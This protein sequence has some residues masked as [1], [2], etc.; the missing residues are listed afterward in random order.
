MA[1]CGWRETGRW[2]KKKSASLRA[3]EEERERGSE[4]EG[5][6]RWGGAGGKKE[7]QGFG[8]DV[9]VS[10]RHPSHSPFL[11]VRSRAESPPAS[12][13]V[14][15]RSKTTPYNGVPAIQATFSSLLCFSSRVLPHIDY[16][17]TTYPSFRLA[18]P[19]PSS[20]VSLPLFRSDRRRRGG[21]RPLIYTCT[22]D[23]NIN[24]NDGRDE[25]IRTPRYLWRLSRLPS[26]FSS[27]ICGRINP[28]PL[29][30]IFWRWIFVV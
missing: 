19:P 17:I 23:H 6:G 30:T 29:R 24:F 7:K 21:T 8:I 2:N 14:P 13:G 20:A 15:P 9:I 27:H 4:R 18:H 16:N 1:P 5:H 3:W 28:L 26:A 25:N 12:H 10:V 22:S 11:R